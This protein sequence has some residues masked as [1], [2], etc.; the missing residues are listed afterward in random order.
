MGRKEWQAST[1][2]QA[3]ALRRLQW[4][5]TLI[6]HEAILW[7]TICIGT[8]PVGTHGTQLTS[9]VTRTT[10]QLASVTPRTISLRSATHTVALTPIGWPAASTP[11]LSRLQTTLPSTRIIAS[12]GL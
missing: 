6:S 12:Q 5:P 8:T 4:P 3:R 10:D 2:S 1:C 11:G 9:T 7:P